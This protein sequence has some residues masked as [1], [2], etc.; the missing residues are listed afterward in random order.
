MKIITKQSL[1]SLKKNL[2]N[3]ERPVKESYTRR[4]AI[5][6]LRPIVRDLRKRGFEYKEIAQ[7]ISEQSKNELKLRSKE[8]EEMCSTKRRAA[9]NNSELTQP[10]LDTSADSLTNNSA[11]D[12]TREAICDDQIWHN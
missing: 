7:V 5:E 12:Q 1:D 4:E 3:V 10:S 11:D 2:E 9:P 8:I 6:A